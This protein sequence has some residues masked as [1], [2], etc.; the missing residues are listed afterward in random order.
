MTIVQLS[1]LDEFLKDS[2]S[3]VRRGVANAR[4]ANQSDPL[5]GI[6]ADLPEKVDFEVMV[7]S[8]YQYLNRLTSSQSVNNEISF[9]GGLD[10]DNQKETNSIQESFNRLKEDAEASLD[11][12]N[13]LD[14]EH[15]SDI[16]QSS[17]DEHDLSVDGSSTTGSDISGDSS[18]Q[19]DLSN[20]L[21]MRDENT[22]EIASTA[23]SK[24]TT[25]K[26]GSNEVIKEESDELVSEINKEIAQEIIGEKEDEVVSEVEGDSSLETSK[27]Q[28]E[29]K[30]NLQ[31]NATGD[32][33]SLSGTY[34]TGV[35]SR[36]ESRKSGSNTSSTKTEKSNSKQIGQ[37]IEWNT[38]QVK[39]FDQAT[40]RWGTQS[41]AP[42]NVPPQTLKCS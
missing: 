16:E 27:E 13:V 17:D 11:V 19:I 41:F 3:I 20:R 28:E 2:L 36:N 5:L 30:E 22:E 18:L 7:V 10:S 32:S 6:M 15:S 37:T 39:G 34:E 21:E 14:T 25:S 42:V 35:S 12:E 23:T 40:G 29:G 26:T 8:S 1:D 4:N 33:V 38:H 24:S 31:D 9:T